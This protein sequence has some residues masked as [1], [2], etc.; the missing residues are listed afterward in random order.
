MRTGGFCKLRPIKG[1]SY[2]PRS[3]QPAAC[4]ALPAWVPA[5]LQKPAPKTKA[6]SDRSVPRSLVPEPL[7]SR[8]RWGF[9]WPDSEKADAQ[10]ICFSSSFQKQDSGK[11]PSL[12]EASSQCCGFVGF[13]PVP[14]NTLGHPGHHSHHPTLHTA[15]PPLPARLGDDHLCPQLVEFVPEL[16]G[17]QAAGNFGHFLTGDDGG[18]GDQRLSTQRGGGWAAAAAPTTKLPVGIQAGQFAQGLGTRWLLNKL[19]CRQREWRMTAD[20]VKQRY[21]MG[22]NAT[23]IGSGLDF[24]K[25]KFRNSRKAVITHQ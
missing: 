21:R 9:S 18:G 4:P 8:P 7:S 5:S 11:K 13:Q 3:K 2:L 15:R 20:A 25:V 23:K 17:L 19:F 10:T 12:N 14:G 24:G 16:L 1:R 6:L 22:N